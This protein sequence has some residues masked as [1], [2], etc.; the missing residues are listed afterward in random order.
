MYLVAR[1]GLNNRKA[2]DKYHR[3]PGTP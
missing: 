3:R 2:R 1:S